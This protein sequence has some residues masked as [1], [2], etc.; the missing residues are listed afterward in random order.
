MKL[1]LL[2]ITVGIIL[3]AGS[4]LAQVDQ[5]QPDSLILEVSATPDATTNQLQ[6]QLDLYVFNDI[7]KLI[8]L[9]SGF[10]WDND[11]LQMDSARLQLTSYLSFDQTFVYDGTD[12]NITNANKR[13]VFSGF[14]FGGKG[15]EP[16]PVRQHLVSYF[17]T[18]SQWNTSDEILID[19]FE[20]DDGSE[21]LFIDF[22]TQD[23]Y[24]P[25]WSGQILVRDSAYSEPSNLIISEDAL[26]FGVIQ[27]ESAPAPQTFEISSDND[28]ISFTVSEAAAWLLKSPALAT[29]PATITISINNF[30]LT[31]GVYQE[32]IL[33]ESAMAANSPQEVLVTLTVEPP[34]AKISVSQRD[35][36]FNAVVDGANPDP[37][38]FDIT[39]MGGQDLHWSVSSTQ[40]WLGLSPGSGTNNGT[41][42]L[43]PDITGLSIGDYV[44][45]VLV[46]DPNA[47]NSPV[48]VEVRLSVASGL[49]EIS[50][51]DSNYFI[52]V[53][54]PPDNPDTLDA[55]G[56]P[57]LDILPVTIEILNT[58]GG[59]MNFTLQESSA[60]LHQL[61]PSSGVAPAEVLVEF[62]VPVSLNEGDHY[63]TLW[64]YSDEATNSPYPVEFHFYARAHPAKIFCPITTLVLE[65]HECLNG[66]RGPLDSKVFGVYNIGGDYPMLATMIYDSELFKINPRWGNAP[67][68]FSVL[69]LDAGLPEGTYFDTIIVWAPTAV[70]NPRIIEVQYVVL[71]S[72][73][74]PEIDVLLSSKGIEVTAQEDSGPFPTDGFDIYNLFFGCMEW[75]F[76]GSVSWALPSISS[77]NVQARVDFIINP[78]GL[79]LGTYTDT[80]LIV[81][82]DATNSPQRL[83][84]TIHMWRLRGDCDQD[85]R[86]NLADITYLI[87]YVYL[88]GSP[89]WPTVE[90]GDVNC[91]GNVNLGDITQLINYVYLNGPILCGNP[92]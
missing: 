47:A 70:N 90:V 57:S 38:S 20:F 62:K 48:R 89:P 22:T 10:G 12:I 58:G 33:I 23:T 40:S 25:V 18:L 69:P 42:T 5:G 76:D 75:Y 56:P 49:P 73:E 79:E 66:T 30:G 43:S 37:Q 44:D 55:V 68:S 91:D 36:L 6:L 64:V 17:F 16:D 59:V 1:G 14:T 7:N 45:T 3:V 84:M 13:F 52:V 32:T 9:S 65:V 15:L 80:I 77:G 74:A 26:E 61:T 2:T 21:L 39:N 46:A 60:R 72:T 50:V 35:F 71:P 92:Y 31:A 87:R 63:D 83:P 88:G 11:N 4:A 78:A 54:L 27:G 29:T 51:V 81:A 19:T 41:V 24:Q 53:D 28:P 67:T 34:P 8:G 82:P 86:I 85:T